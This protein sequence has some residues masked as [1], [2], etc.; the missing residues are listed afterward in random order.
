MNT[1]I[2]TPAPESALFQKT[3]L[4][5]LTREQMEDFFV[6]MGEKKFRAQQLIKWIHQLG[7]DDFE[8]MSNVSKVLRQKLS[9][10]AE[11]RAPE[12]IHREYSADG[13]RKWVMRVGEN[14]MVET[15][16]IPDGDRKTLC[17]SSQVGCALDCS[18]CS[19]GKQGFQ[20]D[21][22]TAEIIGQVWIANRSY[23]ED[24]PVMENRHRA[25]TNVVMMG[26]GEP[27]L[28]FDNVVP[29]MKLMLDDFAYGLSKRRVT[30]ST[31]GVVPMLDKLGEEI[32]V[33]LAVS[34]H[35][36][37]DALRDELVPINRKYPLQE[38]LAASRRY[39]GRFQNVEGGR[40]KITM[41]YVMLAG[42][43]DTPA[44]ARELVKLLKDTPSKIN[45]IP[46][47]PFPHAGYERS[48]REDILAF[49][50]ILSDADY[51]CTVRSTRGDDID[52]ACGQL[53]GQVQD[54]TRRAVRW[55]AKNNDK[56]PREIF[57][58]AT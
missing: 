35:A 23:F 6:S 34:L 18:F 33:A 44:H 48:K 31:S 5:G 3:N 56:N 27:L 47:N 45:L 37:N 16:L 25:L 24:E 17:V 52:A 30:L 51:I 21:L 13:T 58:S 4:L 20:R 9:E 54:R 1:L 53:V 10:V 22:T 39:L 41:E 50:K 29:A 7:V 46:F 32:D 55:Q 57:R 2:T 15:V 12:V 28:N 19:T 43:N 8:Q 36:P 38:L 40:R 14:S 42:V 26:M 11:I 49:Q